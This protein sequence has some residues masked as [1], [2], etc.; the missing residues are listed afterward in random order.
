MSKQSITQALEATSPTGIVQIPEVADRFKQLYKTIHGGN[1]ETFYEAEKFHFAKMISDNKTLQKCTKLSL[2]GIF[3]DVA[4][5]GLSFDPGFKHLYIVPYGTNVGTKDNPQWQ[6][7][8]QLQI[9]GIGE[10]ILRVK[11]GQIKHAD[12]PV[13]VYE[14][15]EFRHGTRN[16]NSFLDHV[17]EVP[18]KGA[19]II[20]CYM[21]ITRSDNTVDYKV[22]TQAD[23]ERFR[24]F[25]KDPNSKAW[26]DGEGGMWIAKCIKHAFKN[27]PKL[28]VGDFSNLQSDTVDEEVEIVEDVIEPSMQ[29]PKTVDYGTEA[30]VEIPEVEKNEPATA[31]APTDNQFDF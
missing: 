19:Q 10:L 8:A 27:Y 16:G 23:M 9:S 1:G 25:S 30:V 2:Y 24:K 11:Q 26:T 12:N 15:D 7:R 5:S 4:V 31:E 21:K 20:A 6:K 18:P 17:A 22:I 29:M 3:M 14:G 28:R 13:I